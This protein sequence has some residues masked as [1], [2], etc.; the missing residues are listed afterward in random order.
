MPTAPNYTVMACCHVVAFAWDT[1]PASA[2]APSLPISCI[3]G[4]YVVSSPRPRWE[5]INVLFPQR[6]GTRHLLAFAV[7]TP[8]VGEMLPIFQRV[9]QL[10]RVCRTP[11]TVP[12][13]HTHL[14]ASWSLPTGTRDTCSRCVLAAGVCVLPAMPL[15]NREENKLAPCVGTGECLRW[16]LN[17]GKLMSWGICPG[18]LES[19]STRK[20]YQQG[21][22]VQE[23]GMQETVQQ[24]QGRCV[25]NLPA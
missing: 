7:C 25:W 5:G 15:R 10:F 4:P 12:G 1:P 13:A 8:V 9:W 2:C 23:A 21:G 14:T 19:C 16:S 6:T 18:L 11:G 24:S 20:C 3:P 17:F 22:A